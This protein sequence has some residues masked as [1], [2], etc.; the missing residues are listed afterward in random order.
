MQ[1][2]RDVSC[3]WNQIVA[4]WRYV[5]WNFCAWKEAVVVTRCVMPLYFGINMIMLYRFYISCVVLCT[6][7]VYTLSQALVIVVSMLRILSFNPRTASRVGQVRLVLKLHQY[8]FQAWFMYWAFFHSQILETGK[9]LWRECYHLNFDIIETWGTLSV[10]VIQTG[11]WHGQRIEP[12]LKFV[13]LWKA[14]SMFF[15]ETMQ[16][17]A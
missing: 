7:C 12:K 16:L 5:L 10:I 13:K 17:L 14:L 2:C 1:L 15:N 3:A 9:S 8:E 6:R 4:V 11:K